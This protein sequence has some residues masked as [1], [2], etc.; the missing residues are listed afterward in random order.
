MM[1]LNV[2]A[3]VPQFS[4]NGRVKISAIQGYFSRIDTCV[5]ELT[6]N[7]FKFVESQT[8]PSITIGSEVYSGYLNEDNTRIYWPIGITAD[9]VL[10]SDKT[11]AKRM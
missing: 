10:P 9:D 7:R 2:L 8:I 5:A 4:Q 1:P 3:V 6:N 11:T